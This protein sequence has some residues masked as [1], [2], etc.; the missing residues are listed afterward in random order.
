MACTLLKANGPSTLAVDYTAKKVTT[1]QQSK[2]LI[3][4]ESDL[5]LASKFTF[6]INKNLV[7]VTHRDTLLHHTQGSAPVYY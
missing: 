5:G 1:R 6:R 3:R 7:S 2:L 4:K